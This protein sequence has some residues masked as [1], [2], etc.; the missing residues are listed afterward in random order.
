MSGEAVSRIP[1]PDRVPEESS[2]PTI[3]IV[4]GGQWSM[5]NAPAQTQ[6]LIPT[7]PDMASTGPSAVR[8]LEPTLRTLQQSHGS[9]N[10]GSVTQPNL[11]DNTICALAEGRVRG[12]ELGL[13]IL[14]LRL[15]QCIL[16]QYGDDHSFAYTLGWLQRYQPQLVLVGRPAGQA[17]PP[18][19]LVLCLRSRIK[20]LSIRL[21]ERRYYNNQQ[22]LAYLRDY[23]TDSAHLALQPILD[24]KYYCSSAIGALFGFLV[25]GSNLELTLHSL[26]IRFEAC[27]GCMDIDPSTVQGLELINPQDQGQSTLFSTLNYTLTPMG[28]RLLRLSILQPFTDIR[29]IEERHNM[30]EAIECNSTDSGKL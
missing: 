29:R 12:G 24:A 10:S 8:T 19:P 23:A 21:I 9:Y 7:P 11:E 13:C 22:G 14:N 6:T 16:A 18:P 2:N 27:E 17:A 28:G 5:L 4:H 15:G 30:V 3:G 20:T 1:Y 26:D 25:N